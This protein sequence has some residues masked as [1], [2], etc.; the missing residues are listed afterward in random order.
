MAPLSWPKESNREEALSW[1]W[2]VVCEGCP[3]PTDCGGQG[4][5]PLLAL[6]CHQCFL[7]FLHLLCAQGGERPSVGV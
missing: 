3:S 5:R 4:G 2:G 1:H 7:F 6:K